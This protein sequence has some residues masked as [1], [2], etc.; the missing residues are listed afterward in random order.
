M[1]EQGIY[2]VYE[3]RPGVAAFERV[4]HEGE[5]EIRRMRRGEDFLWLIRGTDRAAFVPFTADDSFV[6]RLLQTG[7]G[8]LEFNR[9]DW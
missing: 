7:Y 5:V 2:S 1:I 8:W 9:E 3:Y 4:H 6:Y